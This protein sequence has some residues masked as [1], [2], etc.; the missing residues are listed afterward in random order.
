MW[1]SAHALSGLALGTL[2]SLGM[3]LT[4]LCSLALHLA[5]DLVPHWDYTRQRLRAVWACLDVAFAIGMVVA[6]ALVLHLPARAVVAA[7]VSAL[8]DLDVLD[9]IVP[10]PPRPRWFPSH[11]RRF[12]HGRAAPAPGIL[13]QAVV[14][15]GSLTAV[16]LLSR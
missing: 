1:V 2:L 8:P 5:L 14:V 12:P 7:V 3:A 11:W 9:A 4:A 15:F 10:G 6:L 13:V 16:V